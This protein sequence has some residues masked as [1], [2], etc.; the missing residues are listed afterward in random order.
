MDSINTEEYVRALVSSPMGMLE[1][2]GRVQTS[3]GVEIYHKFCGALAFV[4]DLDPLVVGHLANQDNIRIPTIGTDAPIPNYI[5]LLTMKNET[6]LDTIEELLSYITHY[7][8]PLH[9][10]PY[11]HSEAEKQLL[12]QAIGRIV[13]RWGT[14]TNYFEWVSER[15]W[16]DKN[17]LATQ[18][19]FYCERLERRIVAYNSGK[20]YV[21]DKIVDNKIVYCR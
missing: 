10:E 21:F 8:E 16:R 4:F 6:V 5:Q 15:L 1:L 14:A 18:Y 11:E 19:K 3:D 20:G 9:D 13:D 2:M 17:Y 12:R 7:C